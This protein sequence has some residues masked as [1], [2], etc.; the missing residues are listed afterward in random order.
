MAIFSGNQNAR[1]CSL[2]NLLLTKSRLCRTEKNVFQ[3]NFHFTV[4]VLKDFIRQNPENIAASTYTVSRTELCSSFDASLTLHYHVNDVMTS[5][6]RRVIAGVVGFFFNL[7]E[8]VE[9]RKIQCITINPAMKQD[10]KDFV[11]FI[12]DMG[13]D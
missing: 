8:R 13:L 3:V 5:G 9:S 2:Y 6:K 7:K 1:K 4:P 12:T 10:S 11:Q